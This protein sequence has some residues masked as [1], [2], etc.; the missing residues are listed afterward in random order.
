MCLKERG[1]GS[2]L[3]ER[4][5]RPGTGKGKTHTVPPSSPTED[6]KGEPARQENPTETEA[7]EPA[8]L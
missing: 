2:V 7:L 5:V 3:E 1:M 6:G 8:G 4:A